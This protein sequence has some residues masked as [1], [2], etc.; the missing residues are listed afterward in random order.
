MEGKVKDDKYERKLRK[1]V[2]KIKKILKEIDEIHKIIEAEEYTTKV[3]TLLTYL[4][5]DVKDFRSESR[6]LFGVAISLL[7]SL[8]AI[9][10][11]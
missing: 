1:K 3:E 7:L 8:M 5:A 10:L 9:L 6:F 4:S 2:E 11:R